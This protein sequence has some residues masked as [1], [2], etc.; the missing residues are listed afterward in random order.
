MGNSISTSPGGVL[1]RSFYTQVKVRQEN[2]N[3]S[4]CHCINTTKYSGNFLLVSVKV[5]QH[6]RLVK[7]FLRFFLHAHKDFVLNFS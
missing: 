6:G 5:Y 7:Y 2:I 4:A 3:I 1:C